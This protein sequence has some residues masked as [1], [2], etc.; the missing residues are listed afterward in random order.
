MGPGNGVATLRADAWPEQA[1]DQSSRQ[2]HQTKQDRITEPEAM[3]PDRENEDA[4]DDPVN[5]DQQPG[6]LGP[7]ARGR[8][9]GLGR[10]FTGQVHGAC[11]PVSQQDQW[12]AHRQTKP[13]VKPDGEQAQGRRDAAL[14]PEGTEQDRREAITDDHRSH[15]DELNP[16]LRLARLT[17]AHGKTPPLASRTAWQ[18]DCTIDPSIRGLRQLS[19]GRPCPA[20]TESARR[21]QG[22]GR[23][24]WSTGLSW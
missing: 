19:S 14:R 15:I 24:D 1:Q 5:P 12:P 2:R 17:R 11:V 10:L 20:R 7:G 6:H 23:P 21:S 22:S 4:H 16:E 18:T 9:G 13:H 3:Q 8:S